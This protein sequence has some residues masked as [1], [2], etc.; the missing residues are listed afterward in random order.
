MRLNKT[1]RDM[2]R[3]SGRVKAKSQNRVNDV[4]FNGRNIGAVSTYW[5]SYQTCWK[6]KGVIE[7]NNEVYSS[8]FYSDLAAE[9][10]VIQK[11]DEF[12][13]RGDQFGQWFSKQITRYD[14]TQAKMGDYL[15]VSR[16]T[17]SNWCNNNGIPD[18]RNLF[19]IARIVSDI[20]G[21]ELSQVL[22]EINKYMLTK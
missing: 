19:K 10:W 11:Y 20:S 7:W 3:Q 21:R 13:G 14:L 16:V 4:K 8:E 12:Q 1:G 5:D 15:K 9:N 22:L 17:I 6:S 18:S 2:E